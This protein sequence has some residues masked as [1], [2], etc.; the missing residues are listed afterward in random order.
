MFKNRAART[1]LFPLG[2]KA[3]ELLIFD[4]GEN[5]IFLRPLVNFYAES[6]KT[7]RFQ[8]FRHKKARAKPALWE[9]LYNDHA[10]AVK[11]L[12]HLFYIFFTF[13]GFPNETGLMK[14]FLQA[15]QPSGFRDWNRRKTT[16]IIVLRQ[17]LQKA[18]FP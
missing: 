8:A 16:E 12:F 4:N 17:W 6:T 1:H 7:L 14:R 2:T 11:H 15:L 5:I 13:R 9:G 3:L 10:T 18:G